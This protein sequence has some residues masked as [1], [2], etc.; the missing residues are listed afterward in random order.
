MNRFGKYEV[1]DLIGEGGFGKVYRGWDPV[2]K[3]YVAIKTCSFREEHLRR[4]FV[5]EAEVAAGLQHPNIVTVHDFGTE[6][7]E[8]YLVQEYLEG[9]DLDVLIRRGEAGDLERRVSYLRQVAGGLEFA[10]ENDVVHRDVKPANIR[11]SP[12]GRARIMDFGIAKVLTS[13]EGLTRTGMSLGTAGYVSPEQLEDLEI[14]HRADIFS[15]GVLAYELVTGEK[16]FQGDSISQLFYQIS[17]EDPAPVRDVRPDC[18]ASLAG[19]IERCLRKDRRERY[20]SFAEVLGALEGAEGGSGAA[21]GAAAASREGRGSESEGLMSRGAWAALIVAS[22]V[23]TAFGV[24]RYVESRGLPFVGDGNGEAGPAAVVD[25]SA[26][27]SAGDAGE[28]ASLVGSEESVEGATG[29]PAGGPGEAATSP[30][31]EPRAPPPTS[32][33]LVLMRGEGLPGERAAEDVILEELSDGGY[34]VVDRTSLELRSPVPGE[35]SPRADRIGREVGAAVVVLA[36]FRSDVTRSVAGF[37]T[38]SASLSVRTYDTASGELIASETFQ[39]GGGGTPGE[40]ESSPRAAA[41]SAGE[42]VGYQAAFALVQQLRERTA[43]GG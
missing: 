14:D 15:F 8:P 34:E 27:E 43:G 7:D 18:P 22:A 20:A 28:E 10:H 5:Q 1:I 35:G 23:L 2:L 29:G 31:R 19:C 33:V 38:G 6:G 12:D 32:G 4:R 41:T 11:I 37:Y 26:A 25:T 36:D 24:V 30:D 39:V 9:E 16:P 21:A 13:E 40:M 3:R 42:K 17:H